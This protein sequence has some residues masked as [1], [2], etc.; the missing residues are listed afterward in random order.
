MTH[1]AEDHQ[2]AQLYLQAAVAEAALGD[3]EQARQ[4]LEPVMALRGQDLLAMARAAADF[5]DSFSLVTGNEWVTGKPLANAMEQTENLD[6]RVSPQRALTLRLM[7]AW[8]S[9][10]PE[11]FDALFTVAASDAAA[12]DHVRD[13]FVFALEWTQSKAA[14]AANPQS[15]VNA[16][17]KALTEHGPSMWAWERPTE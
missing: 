8:S 5:V 1:A 16:V 9:K 3:V 2:L 12:E 17:C 7:S 14:E 4:R 10:D 15:L 6:E 13:L 11:S